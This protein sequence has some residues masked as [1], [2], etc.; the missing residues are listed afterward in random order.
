MGQN[1]WLGSQP[2]AHRGLYDELD[3]R[4]ENSFA[5]F[6]SAIALGIPFEFDV[7][8]TSDRHAIVVHDRHLSRVTGDDIS[9]S[10]CDSTTLGRL[11]IKSN[12]QPLPTLDQV[13]ELVNGVVPII[14]DVRRW[15]LS[16]DSQ[17]E[18]VVADCVGRYQGPLALQSFD[19]LAVRRLHR[20]VP[21]HPIGQISGALHSAG[22]LRRAIGKTMAT[23]ILTRPDFISYE[24]SELPSPFVEY[25]RN[26]SGPLLTFTAHCDSEERRALE[27]ADNFF[28]SGYMPQSYREPLTKET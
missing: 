5:A 1:N 27:L 9:V 12:G 21:D 10:S 2:I 3:G 14:V 28:F 8:L 16:L 6:E 11:R 7:Q 26:R 4:A 17:L 25:W 23:N 15:G 24:L 22:P 18:H 19:P 20:L 13:L